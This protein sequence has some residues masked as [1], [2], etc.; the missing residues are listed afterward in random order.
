MAPVAPSLP[1]TEQDELRAPAG[2]SSW[3][4]RHTR[5]KAVGPADDTQFEPCSQ[6]Y[7]FHFVLESTSHSGIG[8]PSG[9]VT[10]A[11]PRWHGK[12]LFDFGSGTGMIK[13]KALHFS[14]TFRMQKRDLL[15]R[16]NPFSDRNDT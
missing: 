10:Y 11:T 13:Q 14:A 2:A 15:V 12:H 9:D 8:S 7:G 1:Y 6:F 3:R 4:K 5:L 16:F